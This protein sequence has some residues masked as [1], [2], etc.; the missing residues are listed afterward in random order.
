MFRRIENDVIQE[1]TCQTCRI[2]LKSIHI[3]QLVLDNGH[4][5]GCVI[6]LTR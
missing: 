3:H 1:A 2:R 5:L 4:I 6:K